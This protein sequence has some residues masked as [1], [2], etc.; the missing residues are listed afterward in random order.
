MTICLIGATSGIA[1]A[2]ARREAVDGACFYLTASSA[3]RLEALTR[4]LTVRGAVSV[5]TKV[6]DLSSTADLGGLGKWIQGLPHI[7]RALM[8]TG[9]LTEN[10]SAAPSL[11]R[12]VLVNVGSALVAGEALYRKLTDQEDGGSLVMIGSVAGDRGRQ[13]N[14]CYGAQK[15]AVETFARGLQH[16]AAVSRSSVKVQL[17]KPGP[18]ETRMT[19]HMKPSALMISA[20]AAGQGIQKAFQ[21]SRS[22]VAYLPGRWRFI[23]A[24]IR[25]LPR[26]IFHRLEL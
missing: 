22:G 17:V 2:Y 12:D 20:D 6:L 15:A 3:E 13:S 18:V 5:E 16:K 23:M 8:A 9:V 24:I 11:A 25:S 7:D 4:D 1:T 21:R 19:A 26:F 10:E 14:Y